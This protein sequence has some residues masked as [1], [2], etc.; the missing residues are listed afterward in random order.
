[1]YDGYGT[2]NVFRA[3]RVDGEIPGF[4]IGRDP[5]LDDVVMCD[6]AAPGAAGG[7]VGDGGRPIDCIADQP[8]GDRRS[9]RSLV[10]QKPG[11]GSAVNPPLA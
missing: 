9:A 4:G 10:V 11:W 5:A 3:N 7:L 6:N 2:G 1:V 8:S